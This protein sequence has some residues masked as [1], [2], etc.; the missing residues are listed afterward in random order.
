MAFNWNQKVNGYA[1]IEIQGYFAE[2]FINLALRKGVTLWNIKSI[3][4][5]KVTARV[6]P[7]EY[8][9]LRKIAHT[10]SCKIKVIKKH[11]TSFVLFRYKKRKVFIV[12]I[13]IVAIVVNTV[14]SYIWSVDIVGDFD[15]PIEELKTQ[16][17]EENLKVLARKKDIN[18]EKI[19]INM[20]LKRNDLAWI[21]VDIKGTKATVEIVEKI[22]PEHEE[23]K[24][25]PCNIV[26]IKDGIIEKIYTKE[27]TA[28]VKKGD[29]VQ[30][31]QILI[32]GTIESEHA[33]TRLVHADGEVFARTWYT[34][35][36][37]IPYEKDVISKT[38]NTEKRYKIKILNSEINFLNYGTN[39]EKYDTITVRKQL[40]IFD[41]Y[42]LP[43]EVEEIHYDELELETIKYTR[44]QIESI[45]K[46][47]AMKC[48]L[49]LI[50]NDASVID[51][52][53]SVREYGEG[54]EAE[55]TIECIEKIGTKEKLE[56]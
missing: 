24:G 26:A 50:P 5:G 7:K 2:R 22:L 27:G 37:K 18:I 47:E 53:I 40:K 16:L 36:A 1:E 43:I 42:V 34:Y 20:A 44:N 3:D 48:A 29:L 23:L 51:N 9:K 15:I 13:F 11:G 55:V 19:K 41:K 45:A 33:E 32:S 8:K 4:A 10:T 21:G 17:A 6:F 39:F 25:L 14:N 35:K 54:I 46:N 56:G 49:E 31:G 52:T 30:K 28:I 12:L 38:G